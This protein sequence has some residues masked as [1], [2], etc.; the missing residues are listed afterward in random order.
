VD[1]LQPYSSRV[2]KAAAWLVLLGG[3]VF[4]LSY[5]SAMLQPLVIAVMIWYCVFELRRWVQKIKIKEKFVPTGVANLLAFGVIFLLCWGVYEILTINLEKI[6]EKSPGY[7]ANFK[8][9]LAE[10]QTFE[11]F[12]NVPERALERLQN[13][14]IQPLL[15][16]FLNSLTSAAGNVFVIIIYVAFIL[17]EEKFFYKKLH[18]VSRTEHQQANLDQVID[19]IVK[20]IR[21][22]LSVKTQMSLLTGLLSYFILLA[23]Q[24]DFAVLWAFLIFLLNYIPYI[25]SFFATLFPALF[26]MFQFQSAWMLL[27]VFLAIQVVQF[28]VG[29]VLEPKVMGRQL[30]LSP[31][32]VML[33]LSFWGAIWGIL[34][35]FLS[36]PITSVMLIS[37]SRFEST[38]FIAV[39]LSETG[40]L[41]ST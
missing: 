7:A 6:I 34:G 8:Q 38:R 37:F 32:G 27:W 28:G 26:A 3:I 5:F 41:E 10:F 22:Y 12:R 16:G 35:M 21:Q 20:S 40:E 23:F 31:L 33:A 14:D 29:N 15:T 39:W 19:Q 17:A 2:V 13:I 30:N 18:A 36:V 1:Q 4:T 25:G 9:M 24:V 11:Q